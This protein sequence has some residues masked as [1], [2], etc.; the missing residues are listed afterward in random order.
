MKRRFF[1]TY[2][3]QFVDGYYYYGSRRS[4]VEPSKDVYWGS[5][6]TNKDKWNT[7]QYEKVILD[8]CDT[9]EE[10]MIC[11]SKLIGD[12]YKTDEW[13]LNQHNNG[14]FST[15]G[16]KYSD[17]SREKM[18]KAKDGYIP[19]IKGKHHSEETKRR[20]SEM[21]RGRIHSSKIKLDDVKRIR[22]MYEDTPP[23]PGVGV[24]QKNGR[25]LSYERGFSN[26]FHTMFGITDVNM[27]NI[28]TRRSWVNV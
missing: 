11:E 27:Y 22:S 16:M 12:K 13:C 18:R 6:K 26:T 24:K 15:L 9:G 19:W 25:I 14:N 20:W 28:V 1:Y 5:P 23:I 8:V 7:T 10:M 21:R 3:I 4:F 2:R 17:E